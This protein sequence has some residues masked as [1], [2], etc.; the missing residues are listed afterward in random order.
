MALESMNRCSRSAARHESSSSTVKRR[1]RK[2]KRKKRLPRTCGRAH[3]RQRQWY[4]HGWF[5]CFGA[6]HAVFP[7][8]VCRTQLTRRT[9][10]HRACRRLRQWHL[11]GWFCWLLFALCF[12]PLS[13]DRR[14]FASWPVWNPKD[15]I[16]LSGSG[17]CKAR[18]R[19]CTSRCFLVPSCCQA[20][21][22]GIICPVWTR[23][24]VSWCSWSRPQQ[25]GFFRS[26]SPSRSSTSP[27][28][29]RGSS[30]WSL[31]P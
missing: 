25:T 29:F 19:F 8:F 14:C 11:Q 13:T 30:F 10:F 7:S 2:K 21:M 16:A 4:V 28:W 3:R 12:F 15:C 27:S 26:C 5:C 24:T 17:M 22:L 31:R 20:Q 1:K 18:F 6:P 9:F 23:R